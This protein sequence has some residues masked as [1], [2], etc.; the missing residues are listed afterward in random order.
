ML[1][2]SESLYRTLNLRQDQEVSRYQP[3]TIMAIEYATRCHAIH[4]TDKNL[5]SSNY[6]VKSF[7][8]QTSMKTSARQSQKSQTN[9]IR[10][11]QDSRI[12]LQ[13]PIL[14]HNLRIAAEYPFSLLP[15]LLIRLRLLLVSDLH[16][17]VSTR[18]IVYPSQ[19]PSSSRS[20]PCR[21]HMFH[22]PS[23]ARRQH[24]SSSC[25]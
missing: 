18:Q 24:F 7:T 5:I 23:P 10:I 25:L 19:R 16:S 14:I 22:E 6:V 3:T 8:E 4:D 15:P 17:P 11:L 20:R 2:L 12:S 13:L 1:L 21:L 9:F